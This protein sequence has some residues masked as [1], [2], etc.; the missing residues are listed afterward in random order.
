MNTK[1][2]DYDR[3]FHFAPL[4]VLDAA[5]NAFFER[6]LEYMIPKM[7]EVT[8]KRI[9]GRMLFP[10]DRGANPGDETIV[11][12][13]SEEIG[14]AAIVAD[15]ADDIPMVSEK[16]EEF[17]QPI[18]PIACG[19]HW[20]IK[21]IQAAAK[22]GRP[23][24]ASRAR[25]ARK[26]ILKLENTLLFEGSEKYGVLGLIS[27]A[28][29]VGQDQVP[30]GGSGRPWSTKSAAQILLDMQNL[31]TA[32]VVT[33]GGDNESPTRMV[34]PPAQHELVFNTSMGTG[35][36]TT[37]GR[38]FLNNQQHVKEILSANE[39][40][41]I[42]PGGT[43]MFLVYDPDPDN[44]VIHVPQEI[45]QLPPTRKNL[46]TQVVYLMQTGG[47]QVKRPVSMRLGYNI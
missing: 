38:Y 12:R 46:T 30:D 37:I 22:V 19:A 32:N 17:R 43:D 16:T 27:S 28:F 4:D 42:G 21:E 44:V 6:E 10:I 7:V 18:R 5:E 31:V 40:V 9:N 2:Y 3:D 24:D 13:Q 25:T 35:T 1:I 39:L 45:T 20:S 11:L 23:L 8:Y 15:F 47:L 36:D 29:G 26:R 41:G 34:L 14:E 33:H